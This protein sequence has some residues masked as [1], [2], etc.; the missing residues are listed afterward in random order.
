MLSLD[1]KI[2]RSLIVSDLHEQIGYCDM[3]SHEFIHND[4]KLQKTTFEDGTT[5]Y[6]DLY[7]QTYKIVKP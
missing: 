7:Q 6:I 1:E 4:Y 2:Q 3:L 5:V